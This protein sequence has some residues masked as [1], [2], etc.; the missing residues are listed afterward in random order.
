MNE[1]LW[2]GRILGLGG[3]LEAGAGLGLL[4]APSAVASMLLR[5]PLVGSGVT[6]AR[7][8]GGGLLALGIACWCAREAPADPAGMGVAWGFLAY[9]V[10]ACVTLA[11]ARPPLAQGGFPAVGVSVLHGALGAG[12]TAA[13]LGWA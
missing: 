7:L 9:N 6:V 5:S 2:L 8:G 11:R 1:N 3:V 10:I 12:L 4:L 13:L